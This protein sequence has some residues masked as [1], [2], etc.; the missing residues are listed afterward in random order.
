MKLHQWLAVAITTAFIAA[1]SGGG[2]DAGVPA[3]NAPVTSTDTF[4]VKAAYVNYFNDTRSYPFTVSGTASGFSVTG[5]GTVTQSPV[6]NGLFEG[7]AVLQKTSTVSG[8]VVAN[9]VTISLAASDTTFVDSNYVAKGWSGEEYVVVT[10]VAVVPDTAKVNDSGPWHT[11]NRYADSSKS[12][13]LGSSDVSFSLA[14]DTATTALLKIIQVDKDTVGNTTMTMTAVFRMTPAGGLT[15]LSE[16][17][18]DGSSTLTL[19]Y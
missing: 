2:G 14:P 7:A 6:T 10:S 3:S 19:T 13:L 9:G 4:Q 5:S 12:T 16:T 17:A 1:C 15:R 8:S 18:V 11:S